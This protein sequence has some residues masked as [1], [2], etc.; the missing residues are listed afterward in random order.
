[1]V[2]KLRRRFTAAAG[3]FGAILLPGEDGLLTTKSTVDSEIKSVDILT[4][5]RPL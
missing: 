1:M 5:H 3:K 4:I 2:P